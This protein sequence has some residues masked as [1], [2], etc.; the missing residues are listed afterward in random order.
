MK[1][2][3][4]KAAALIIL[5]CATVGCAGHVIYDP[6]PLPALNSSLNT[7]KDIT[8]KQRRVYL[9]CDNLLTGPQQNSYILPQK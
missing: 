9:A 3:T 5:P 6:S 8:V 7:I 4:L 1:D 2:T